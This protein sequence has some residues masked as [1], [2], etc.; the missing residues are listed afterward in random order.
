MAR[1]KVT[2]ILPN[3]EVATRLLVVLS[4]DH[5][6]SD[7]LDK[8]KSRYRTDLPITLHWN[9]ADGPIL[10]TD[11]SLGDTLDETADVVF[12]VLGASEAPV[13]TLQSA[14]QSIDP[15]TSQPEFYSLKVHV[16]TPELARSHPNIKD[17]PLMACNIT[18]ATTLKQL[19]GHVEQ[20]LGITNTTQMVS[21][22]EHRIFCNCSFARQIESDTTLQD[23]R[24]AALG[25]VVVVHD[26]NQVT[27]LPIEEPTLESIKRAVQRKFPKEV[28]QNDPF[29]VDG[30]EEQ[31]FPGP[32]PRY[33]KLPV[34]ALCTSIRHKADSGSRDDE[35]TDHDA[36]TTGV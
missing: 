19:R 22:D 10:F 1:Y 31:Q 20:H 13:S 33:L 32:D 16:I 9:S 12:A 18:T 35:R 34:V 15:H 6:C 7:L 4:Q 5:L 21:D 24:N 8:I 17:I 25:T 11:D 3:G 26:Q 14:S 2:V 30:I 29:I 28:T 23:D 27:I 36:N